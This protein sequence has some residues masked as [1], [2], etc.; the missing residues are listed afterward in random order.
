[1]LKYVAAFSL[2]LAVPSFAEDRLPIMG[3]EGQAPLPASEI[4]SEAIITGSVAAK[5]RDCTILNC[6]IQEKFIQTNSSP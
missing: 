6:E 3:N 1:M 2:M 5:P 4:A